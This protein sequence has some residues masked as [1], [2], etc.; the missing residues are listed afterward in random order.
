M[1]IRLDPPDREKGGMNMA[2]KDLKFKSLP[3]CGK[4]DATYEEML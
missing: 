4:P 2:T 1:Q 3:S